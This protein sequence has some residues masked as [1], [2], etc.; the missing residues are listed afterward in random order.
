MV[1]LH[2][3]YTFSALERNGAIRSLSRGCGPYFG[4]KCEREINFDR[5]DCFTSCQGDLCNS[6]SGYYPQQ[7]RNRNDPDVEEAGESSGVRNQNEADLDIENEAENENEPGGNN[8]RN[9][10]RSRNN[11][12]NRRPNQMHVE[13]SSDAVKMFS[14]RS[15]ILMCIICLGVLSIL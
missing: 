1:S 3:Y 2:N 13:D 8:D 14:R 11:V 7:P 9:G 15:I 6:G 5:K 10:I 4:N 12:R